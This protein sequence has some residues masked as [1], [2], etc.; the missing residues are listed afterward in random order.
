MFLVAEVRRGAPRRAEDSTRRTVFRAQREAQP[1]GTAA[2]GLGFSQG[3]KHERT[4]AITRT[5]LFADSQIAKRHWSMQ[6]AI[7]SNPR[8]LRRPAP[9]QPA[10]SRMIPSTR[11]AICGGPLFRCWA[12]HK[13]TR[14]HRSRL[15]PAASVSRSGTP[16]VIICLDQVH[17]G[18][19]R[20]PA[21]GGKCIVQRSTNDSS[22]PPLEE[23]RTED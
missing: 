19:T 13:P 16:L 14:R 12:R 1:G 11:R 20:P 9:G 10:G 2:A 5:S 18:L 7:A 6:I 17:D 3:S 22:S 15:E 8:I 21:G 23:L 4:S